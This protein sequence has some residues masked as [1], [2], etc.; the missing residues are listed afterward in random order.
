MKGKFSMRFVNVSRLKYL[1]QGEFSRVYRLSSQRVIKVY[2]RH[3][4]WDAGIMA[5]EIELS[6]AS[7]HALPVLDVAIARRGNKRFYAVIKKY[8]PHGV[9][10]EEMQALQRKLPAKLKDDCHYGNVRKDEKGKIFLIDTQG[11]YAFDR[12]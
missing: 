4:K 1:G 11:Q 5:E 6:M 12:M 7:P 8:I 10:W 2:D 3:D 9:T